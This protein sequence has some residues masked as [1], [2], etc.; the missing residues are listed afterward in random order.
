MQELGP[1]YLGLGP[2]GLGK[3]TKSKLELDLVSARDRHKQRQYK[4]AR[5][6]QKVGIVIL[7]LR[8]TDTRQDI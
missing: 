5:S 1:E 2:K 3:W 7:A 6:G 8:T 4:Q